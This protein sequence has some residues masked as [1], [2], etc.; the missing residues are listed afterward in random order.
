MSIYNSNPKNY[1]VPFFELSRYNLIAPVGRGLKQLNGVRG[2]LEA[3]RYNLIAPS[4]GTETYRDLAIP[5]LAICA[6]I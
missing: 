1:S 5:L 4:K 3:A 2:E 6:T